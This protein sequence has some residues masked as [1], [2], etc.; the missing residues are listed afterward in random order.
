M[1]KLAQ[2]RLE[3]GYIRSIL[4]QRPLFSYLGMLQSAGH[5]RVW[6]DYID[7]AFKTLIRTYPEIFTDGKQSYVCSSGEVKSRQNI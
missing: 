2:F 4:K 3:N 5:N 6:E 1:L 7:S